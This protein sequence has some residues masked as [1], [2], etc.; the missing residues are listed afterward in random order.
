MARGTYIRTRYLNS[1]ISAF[2]SALSA[3]NQLNSSYKN[4]QSIIL[5]TNAIELIAKSIL[6]KLGK[7][8]GT[9]TCHF[10][11]LQSAMSVSFGL[12]ASIVM[13][14]SKDR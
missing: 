14:L 2:Y 1:S 7:S 4:E 12:D 5:M 6:L 11:I 3:Y 10:L 8:I 9:G 13:Q